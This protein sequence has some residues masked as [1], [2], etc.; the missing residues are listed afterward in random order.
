MNQSAPAP[1]RPKP[2]ETHL[3]ALR[4]PQPGEV[5]SAITSLVADKENRV[6]ILDDLFELID[7]LSAA[8]YGPI[9]TGLRAG[10]PEKYDEIA[11]AATAQQAAIQAALGILGPRA[12]LDESR[13]V[14]AVDKSGMLQRLGRWPDHV[15]TMRAEALRALDCISR[16]VR[17]GTAR[18]GTS[19]RTRRLRSP[20]RHRGT[21]HQQFPQVASPSRSHPCGR[22][23]PRFHGRKHAGDLL[24]LLRQHGRNAELL[25][26]GSRQGRR[27]SR[28]RPRRRVAGV[29]QPRRHSVHAVA[30]R[31]A[32]SGP[33]AAATRKR[34]PSTNR[35]ALFPRRARLTGRL[36]RQPYS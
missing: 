17:L 33:R 21:S 18:Q 3:Q 20:A 26:E 11:K 19:V 5:R 16:Q 27:N 24:E 29:G 28:P 12:L 14:Q 32:A 1:S 35:H 22:S 8:L 9:P 23:E 4:N 36:R 2:W 31:S 30:G 34:L 6:Q 7:R 13:W 10:E 15:A 25:R